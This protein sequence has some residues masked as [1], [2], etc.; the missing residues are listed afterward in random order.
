[1]GSH[2]LLQG[3]FPIQG[4]NTCLLYLLQWQAGSLPLGHL[5]SPFFQ[6]NFVITD[7]NVFT[8]AVEGI[9]YTPQQ[10]AGLW[11]ATTL[12]KNEF[13]TWSEICYSVPMI[14][15]FLTP[16]DWIRTY[17]GFNLA[18]VSRWPQMYSISSPNVSWRY[19]AYWLTSAVTLHCLCTFH[20]EGHFSAER[21]S[22]ANIF[23]LGTCLKP[24]PSPQGEL[25]LAS[26]FLSLLHN[27]SPLRGSYP[28]YTHGSSYSQE[29][30]A[31]KELLT[32]AS[33]IP[34][35]LPHRTSLHS[36]VKGHGCF[37]MNYPCVD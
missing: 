26:N 19:S 14:G 16:K 34:S 10:H 37:L 11:M 8:T 31:W 29:E 25:S 3:I 13:S 21:R 36:Y 30:M 33:Y 22:H 4:S 32:P 28:P 24:H 23:V 17:F 35:L 18:F 12:F 15:V 5:G 7:P 27:L 2:C 20:F 1:M 9:S 6:S